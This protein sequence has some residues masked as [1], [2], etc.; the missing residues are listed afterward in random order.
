MFWTDDHSIADVAMGS[1]FTWSV[2]MRVTAKLRGNKEKV[3]A[4]GII[5]K[6]HRSLHFEQQSNLRQDASHRLDRHAARRSPSLAQQRK[7]GFVFG[8]TKVFVIRREKADVALRRVIYLKKLMEISRNIGGM[9]KCLSR[10]VSPESGRW[11]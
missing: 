6:H 10:D 11:R 4:F 8:K 7:C 9:L 1:A 2:V 5:G 3:N